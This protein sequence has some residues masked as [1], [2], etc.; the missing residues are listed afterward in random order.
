MALSLISYGN[1]RFFNSKKRI[2]QEA[3]LMQ[4]FDKIIMYD[5]DRLTASFKTK[6]ANIIALKKG[7]GYYIWKFDIIKQNLS[8]ME[9]NDILIYIDSGC[10]INLF[11][12]NRLLDYINLLKASD[13]SFL[14]FKST[15]EE[16]K[17]TIKETFDLN[18]TPVEYRDSCQ[19]I[20]TVML[21]KKTIESIPFIDECLELIDKDQN[22]LTDVYNN[23]QVDQRF[24][25]NRADQSIFSIL[26]KKYNS[27]ILD[28]ETWFSDFNCREAK[29]KPFLATRIRI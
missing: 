13:K 18:N 8:N 20:A 22:I 19:L 29:D 12:K 25:D 2:V 23:N 27:I 16:Y 9:T 17:F 15:H 6:Y 7:C 21:F 4:V 5:E 11:G 28:D 10:T 26:R 1:D 3:Q 24:I 14:S